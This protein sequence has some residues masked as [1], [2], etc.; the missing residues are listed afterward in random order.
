MQCKSLLSQENLEQ[1]VIVNIQYLS[2]LLEKCQFILEQGS[3]HGRPGAMRGR[4]RGQRAEVR[5]SRHLHHLPKHPRR[6][7]L[8]A[9]RTCRRERSEPVDREERLEAVD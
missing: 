2:D 1:V 5:L 3:R 9:T 7:A 4:L 6:D 8:R